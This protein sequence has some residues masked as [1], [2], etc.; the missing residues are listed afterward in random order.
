MNPVLWNWEKRV[1]AKKKKEKKKENLGNIRIRV[2]IL[3]LRK[4]RKWLNLFHKV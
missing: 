1:E 4:L 2:Y 3:V